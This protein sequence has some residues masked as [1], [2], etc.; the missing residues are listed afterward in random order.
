MNTPK[1]NF[2]AAISRQ[3][4]LDAYWQKRPVVLR[5]A[6]DPNLCGLS[7]DELAGL[8]CEGE[9]ESR[10][11]RRYAD[12][13]WS[14][15]HGPLDEQQFQHLPDSDWTLLV[16]DVDKHVA[17]V[18][19]VLDAF[20]FLPDW[21]LDDIM[22]SYATDQGGVG[23]HTDNYDVFLMQARGQRRWRLSER[24]YGE[25]DLL[26]DAPLRILKDFH[27]SE[28]LI[29]SPGDILYL[30]PGVA[31]WGTAIGECMTWSVGMRGNSDT[32]LVAAWLEQLP[33]H[34]GRPHLRDSLDSSTR[35][36]SMLSE[37]DLDRIQRLMAHAL[38]TDSP[39][40]RR[41]LGCHLTE[42]KPGFE[43]LAEKASPETL[44]DQWLQDA[45]ELRRHPWARFALVPLANEQIA[46]YCQ[47]QGIE[48][49]LEA[50]STLEIICRQRRLSAA[51]LAT[52]DLTL[53]R[54]LI[55]E[56]VQRGWLYFDQ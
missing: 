8:A 26:P 9:V 50:L 6:I 17:E 32:E 45:I 55:R 41:W 53:V 16:Q 20:D 19:E 18:A 42:P 31:H 35:T 52:Q 3:Q 25:A 43:I 28:D 46:L 12:N 44:M 39:A 54:K 24:H 13:H 23:P 33:M 22:I 27:T 40:F 38:P 48:Y 2:Q 7:P 21:R 47:G 5:V 36:P 30:P 49:P 51:S 10:L 1:I 29:L 34:E 56:L 37:A 11:I 15:R 14:L 4:F